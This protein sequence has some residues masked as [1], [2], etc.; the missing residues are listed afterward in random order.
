[1]S[2]GRPHF[3]EEVV[4]RGPYEPVR[5]RQLFPREREWGV[6]V[7]PEPVENHGAFYFTGSGIPF[8]RV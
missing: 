5:S 1:M 3:A 2:T 7:C 6:C 8:G 4:Q